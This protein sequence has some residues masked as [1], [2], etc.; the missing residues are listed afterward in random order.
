[1]TQPADKH[2]QICSLLFFP[3]S[4]V[5]AETTPGTPYIRI[6]GTGEKIDFATAEFSETA[7]E[8]GQ[9]IEQDFKAT[10]TNTGTD[11]Y[12]RLQNLLAT[13]GL[14]RIDYTNQTRHII[15]TPDA[16][17]FISLK[18]SGT[19]ATLTLSFI[20]TSPEFSKILLT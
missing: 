7:E 11:V 18:Q 12:I 2:A 4:G 19:V 15:G 20:R 9:P 17:V 8:N 14:L 6:T 1:M 13:Y 3:L 16:P 5:T 10:V